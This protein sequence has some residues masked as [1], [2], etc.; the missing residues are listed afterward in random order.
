MYKALGGK[1][2]WAWNLLGLRR[3]Q[4]TEGRP[5]TSELTDLKQSLCNKIGHWLHHIL[6]LKLRFFFS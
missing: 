3:A 5:Q 2:I 4:C 1:W 6:T